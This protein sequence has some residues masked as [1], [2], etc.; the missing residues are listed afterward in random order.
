MVALRL[1]STTLKNL[2]VELNAFVE[3][4][5]QIS[6][7]EKDDGS[8]KDYHNIRGAKSV[9]DVADLGCMMQ[10]PTINELTLVNDFVKQCEHTPNLI[11]DIYKNRRGRWTMCRIWSYINLGIL[12][13]KDLF[14][15]SS[16][17]KP[18]EDFSL[19]N[20]T[21]DEDEELNKFVNK[22][23]NEGYDRGSMRGLNQSELVSFKDF[24]EQSGYFEY[25]SGHDNA[26]GASIRDKD[27][28]DFHK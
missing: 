17:N 20:I 15:T 28:A 10:R 3:T 16:N 21:I 25:V 12:R 5:T 9:A 13:K 1:L 24:L 7:E 23:N 27:L 22:L 2:A 26:A 6:N 19:M 11:T 4:S 18:L 14:I 8:F